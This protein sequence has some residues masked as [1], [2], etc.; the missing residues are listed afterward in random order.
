MGLTRV[1]RLADKLAR[2]GEDI[3]MVSQAIDRWKEWMDAHELHATN[4][5]PESWAWVREAYVDGYL[6]GVQKKITGE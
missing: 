4:M 6:R 2:K 1:Q 3:G 5:S